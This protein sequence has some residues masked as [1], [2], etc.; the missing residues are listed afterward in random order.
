MRTHGAYI[1]SALSREGGIQ[2]ESFACW[3]HSRDGVTRRNV[4]SSVQ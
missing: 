3:C 2:T 1:I 4:D